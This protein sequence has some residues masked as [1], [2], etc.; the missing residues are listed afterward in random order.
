M[1]T[2]DIPSPDAEPESVT[3]TWTYIGRRYN[4]DE[5]IHVFL[6]KTGK[7][8][9]FTGKV[10]A[11]PGI[12]ARYSVKVTHSDEGR[13]SAGISAAQYLGIHQDTEAIAAWRADHAAVETNHQRDLAAR[14][15]ARD[16]G[17]VGDL[18]FRQAREILRRQ[19]TPLRRG[20]FAALSEWL[21]RP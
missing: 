2:P 21:L 3:E 13:V 6:D 17:D 5:L 7:E 12:G 15:F 9:L 14:R 1:S 11:H 10:M 19:P 18:T 4:A 8:R 20:T 16:N